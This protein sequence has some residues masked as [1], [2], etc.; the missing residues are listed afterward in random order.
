[1]IRAKGKSYFTREQALKDLQIKSDSLNARIYRLKQKGEIISPSENLYVIVPPEYRDFGCMPQEELV[2]ILMRYKKVD[3]Y[4]GLLTA[5]MYHGASHQ[6][7]QL[8]QVMTN[9]QLK[10][11]NFGKVRIEFIYKKS[12]INLP[13]QN[14]NVKTGY[15]KISSPELTAM[16]LLL[17]SKRSGGL[18]HI[19]SVLSELV[20][21]VNPKKLTTV[22]RIS[23]EK[24]WLQR[25]GYILDHINSVNNKKKKLIISKLK[26]LLS[27]QKLVYMPLASELPIKGCSRNDKWMIIENTTIESDYDS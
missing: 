20:E 15:L 24:T 1:M 10:S 27:R 13:T 26:K 21:A 16:D 25:L 17:Y 11:L 7:P 18:N 19:A 2:P 12:F 3:Y 4:A 22:A 23:G 14:V 9:K 8:F 6:K 5:A